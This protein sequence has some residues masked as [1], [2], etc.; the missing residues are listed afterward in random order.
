M[1]APK[2]TDKI[3]PSATARAR[4]AKPAAP[5]D[6]RAP[7]PV[8]AAAKKNTSP[9]PARAKP[10]QTRKNAPGTFPVAGK[11]SDKPA[12]VK[13]TKRIRD[14]FTMPK[15]EYALIAILK[16]RC[17]DAGMPAKKSEILR[18]AIANLAKLSDTSVVSAVRKL[19][20][21]KTGRPAKA[22]R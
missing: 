1:T 19:Q 13:K 9:S 6:K 22:S 11:E 17:L 14:S 7:P 15:G 5:A 3:E 21:F 16:K 18:A 2:T 12:K 10:A 20:T 8:K 4:G